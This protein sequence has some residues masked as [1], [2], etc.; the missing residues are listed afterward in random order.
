M[1]VTPADQVDGAY[2]GASARIHVNGY[3]EG[4]YDGSVNMFFRLPLPYQIDGLTVYITEIKFYGYTSGNSPYFNT[5]S[6]RASDLDGSITDLISY[7]DDI[8]NGSSG[9]TGAVTI[10]SG[11]LAMV[12]FP[13]FFMIDL[14]GTGTYADW[15]VYG[16]RIAWTT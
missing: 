12:D 16:M 13:T 10:Y 15:R 9:D 1:W 6:L 3:S 4:T 7:T 2:N 8:G 14:A 5:I 11:S